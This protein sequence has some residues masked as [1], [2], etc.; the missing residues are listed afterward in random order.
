MGVKLWANCNLP[1]A[2]SILIAAGSGVILHKV[3]L[4]V[5]RFDWFAFALERGGEVEVEVEGKVTVAALSWHNGCHL[6]EVQ[7]DR[8]TGR[9]AVT[10]FTAVDD[11]TA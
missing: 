5:L 1:D 10:R 2:H 9:I 11:V 6:G 4:H 8:E 7:I 3:L